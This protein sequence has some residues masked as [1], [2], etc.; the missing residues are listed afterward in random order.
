MSDTSKL[1]KTRVAWSR[2][3]CLKSNPD[4]DIR[5]PVTKPTQRD[6]AVCHPLKVWG[7]LTLGDNGKPAQR[8][9]WRELQGVGMSGR[10]KPH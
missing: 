8:D 3:N 9:T 10:P 7:C 5:S 2:L 1:R 4:R 6:V